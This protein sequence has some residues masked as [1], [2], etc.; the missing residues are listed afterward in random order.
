MP[1]AGWFEHNAGQVPRGFCAFLD[2]YGATRGRKVLSRG[3]R[4]LWILAACARHLGRSFRAITL[5]LLVAF[6][7]PQ[8]ASAQS[9]AVTYPNGGEVWNVGSTK[10]IQWSWTGSFTSFTLQISRDGGS[11]WSTI[12]SGLPGNYTY[13]DWTVTGPAS[14]SCR[15]KVIGY[16]SGGSISDTSNANFTR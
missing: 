2:S 10:R 9:I 4:V 8:A 14:S 6:A 12:E 7:I 15:V 13:R 5:L 11:S 1:A 16:Y 3:E